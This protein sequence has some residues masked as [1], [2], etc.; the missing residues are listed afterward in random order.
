MKK[1]Y[2]VVD[3]QNMNKLTFFLTYRDSN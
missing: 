1:V 3:L 2:M